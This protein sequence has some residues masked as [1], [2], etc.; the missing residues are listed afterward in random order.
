MARRPT[1]WRGALLREEGHGQKVP[2]QIHSTPAPF[3]T[4][5]SGERQCA[6][7]V[8]CPPRYPGI[9]DAQFGKLR[10]KGIK[11]MDWRA[12]E[13]QHDL[14]GLIFQLGIWAFCCAVGAIGPNCVG[15]DET[16]LLRDSSEHMLS[17]CSMPGPGSGTG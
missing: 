17:V 11:R 7:P 5:G 13:V 12:Q 4:L 1:L 3:G 15:M 6:H 16:R 2:L 9:D 14:E 10:C 8:V